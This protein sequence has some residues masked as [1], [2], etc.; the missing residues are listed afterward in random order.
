MLFIYLCFMLCLFPCD[1]YS[2]GEIL[3]VLLR[4]QLILAVSPIFSVMHLIPDVCGCHALR[5][6][7][8]LCVGLGMFAVCRRLL[9]NRFRLIVWVL[10]LLKKLVAKMYVHWALGYENLGMKVFLRSHPFRPP[11]FCCFAPGRFVR[12]HVRPESFR[13]TIATSPHAASPNN[14]FYKMFLNAITFVIDVDI[15]LYSSLHSVENV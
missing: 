13:I 10:V 11:F 6:L 12:S 3:L 5:I 9:I 4:Q 14:R 7:A 8:V 1:L 2:D 15:P